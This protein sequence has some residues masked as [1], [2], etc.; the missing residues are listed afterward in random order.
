MTIDKNGA[1]TK[2]YQ[3]AFAAYNPLV[4]SQGNDVIFSI[5]RF[6]TGGHYN[7]SNGR[8]TA[9]VAGKYIFTYSLLMRNDS[10]Y[11]R[12]LF[13]INGVASTSYG[14]SL[15]GGGN[16][17]AYS[18]WSYDYSAMSVILPLNAGDYVTIE[19][20]GP[21]TTYGESYGQF[22]GYLLG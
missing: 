22:S 15:A 11:M 1:V 8:F 7:S 4:T 14:D 13:A 10:S 17:D 20:D 2:P 12:I 5:N 16:S 9:P 19:N 21:Q 6:N 3:P 18:G